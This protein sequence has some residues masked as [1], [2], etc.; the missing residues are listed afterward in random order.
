MG[1]ARVSRIIGTK[2]DFG[3]A[4]C[5]INLNITSVRRL[6]VDG[7]AHAVTDSNPLRSVDVYV[8]AVKTCESDRSAP[9]RPLRICD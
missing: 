8:L 9:I 1:S 6:G 7:S 5:R 4:T 3:V 2:E